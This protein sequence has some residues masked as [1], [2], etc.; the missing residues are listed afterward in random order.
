[1]AERGSYTVDDLPALFRRRYASVDGKGRIA[2]FVFP[3]R[4]IWGEGEAE[5]FA[6]DVQSVD[7][8]A[9]G[10]AISMHIHNEMIIADFVRAALLAVGIVFVVLFVDFRRVGDTILA[11]TPVLLGGCWT[12]GLMVAVGLD[13]GVGNILA[14]PFLIGLGIDAGVHMVHRARQSQ[15]EH[16][17]GR[18]EDLLAGTGAAVL[19]ASVTTIVGFGGLMLADYGALYD[20]GFTMVLGVSCTLFATL[21]VLPALLVALGRAE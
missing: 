16:G 9:A 10:H 1:V 7:P 20:F 8:N 5:R 11:L 4:P 14:A 18:L 3:D 13:F 17:K 15:E 21:F 12:A 19:V 6:S 2:L